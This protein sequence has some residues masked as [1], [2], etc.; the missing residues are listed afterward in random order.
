MRGIILAGGTGTRLHPIT[1][2]VS[3]QL[4]P[5]YDKP[6]IYYPLSTL[7]LAGHSRHP[8]DHHARTRP[9]Q[10]QRLLGDGSQFG[11]RDHLRR[12]AQP[13]RSGAGVPHRRRPHRRRPRRAGARRQHLLRRRGCGSQLRRFADDRRRRRLRLPG[14]R[15]ARRT[16][17]SSSTRTARRCRSRRSPSSPRS[18]F[19][20][21]GLYFYGNDVVE[22]ARDA[23]A[24]G[25]RRAR[26]H[27]PQPDLPRGRP[28][29]GRGAAARHRLARHRHVRLAQ[30]RQQLR[31]HHRG[32]AGHQD[33]LPRGGRL[34]DGLLAD[35]E[36]RELAG[37]AEEERV[38]RV[39]AG[40]ARAGTRQ[41]RRPRSASTIR[42]TSSSKLDRRR[43]AEQLPGPGRVAGEIG[44]R[45]PAGRAPGRCCTSAS[46]SSMPARRKAAA[47]EVAHG[48][49]RRRW[50]RR[51]RRR[52]RPGRPGPSRRRSRAPSPSRGGRR[53]CRA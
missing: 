27:R 19:A 45:R 11:H 29:P 15:P 31:A 1:Q 8:G 17:W 25:A 33:R 3:K 46:Q 26:D 32:P 30:R 22:L 48:V 53:G 18:N 6:M 36:L 39:P 12:A 2:A 5:V 38:R 42:P 7:M 35:D 20:V 52:P 23:E 49:A 41:A 34:A 37:A 4:V 14:R 16:A 13:R 51:S 10:F 43:P 40:P 50:P 44:R 28:A 47:D 21:P 24:V 9:R